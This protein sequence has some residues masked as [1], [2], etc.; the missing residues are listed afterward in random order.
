[1]TLSIVAAD[2]ERGD[3]GVAVASKF[4]AVGAIVPLGPTAAHEP[5]PIARGA[6]ARW[7]SLGATSEH[8]LMRVSA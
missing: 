1:L 3:V 4:I 2:P 5:A 8:K 6:W 7:K